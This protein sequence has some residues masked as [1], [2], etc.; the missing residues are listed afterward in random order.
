MARTNEFSTS[1]CNR[2]GRKVA[3]FGLAAMTAGTA[4]TI[5]MT[6]L[7]AAPA[8]AATADSSPM[9]AASPV[10]AT[11]VSTRPAADAAVALGNGSNNSDNA[12]NS[13]GWGG[14]VVTQTVDTEADRT[15]NGW[16]RGLDHPINAA[17][18][19]IRGAARTAAQA[20]NATGPVSVSTGQLSTGTGSL[21]CR[22]LSAGAATPTVSVTQFVHLMNGHWAIWSIL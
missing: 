21:T 6:A 19:A 14:D 17:P 3:M 15:G 13:N 4:A 18:T 8:N 10:P 2:I 5:G 11:A 7:A 20:L 16:A 12:D 9:C 1:F 22:A